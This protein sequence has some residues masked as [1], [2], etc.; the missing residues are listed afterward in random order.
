MQG[1]ANHCKL[2]HL[3]CMVQITGLYWQCCPKKKQKMPS[4]LPSLAVH[5]LI[6]GQHVI[7]LV[8]SIQIA[9]CQLHVLDQGI[10]LC[11]VAL[12]DNLRP[13]VGCT[14]PVFRRQVQTKELPHWSL[15]KGLPQRPCYHGKSFRIG[16]ILQCWSVD[17]GQAS[18]DFVCFLH[19]CRQQIFQ[20]TMPTQSPTGN[21]LCQLHGLWPCRLWCVRVCFTAGSIWQNQIHIVANHLALCWIRHQGHR[22]VA[23]GNPREPSINPILQGWRSIALRYGQDKLLASAKNFLEWHGLKLLQ[24]LPQHLLPIRLQQLCCKFL[25]LVILTL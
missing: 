2:G 8:D 13:Q 7:L 9:D 1:I 24:A 16:S 6:H 23:R 18:A 5:R 4:Y 21:L 22:A 20:D 15:S 3:S 11:Y 25:G 17:S 12:W 19:C 10:A 14:F